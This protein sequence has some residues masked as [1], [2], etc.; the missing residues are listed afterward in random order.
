MRSLNA[1]QVAL[2]SAK[3]HECKYFGLSA[4]QDAEV[5]SFLWKVGGR[6]NKEKFADF[7]LLNSL[8]YCLNTARHAD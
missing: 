1:M 3:M 6:A 7:I 8:Q 2:D 4:Y 5:Q